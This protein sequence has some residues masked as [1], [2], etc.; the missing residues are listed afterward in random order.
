MW[1]ITSILG[2]ATHM[3]SVAHL[4]ALAGLAEFDQGV[5]H[6]PN[7]ANRTEGLSLEETHLAAWQLE[8][9]EA[10]I[11]RQDNCRS[12]GCSAHHTTSRWILFHIV[13]HRADRNI[14]QCQGI[15]NK[16][17]RILRRNHLLPN[18]HSGGMQ[19]VAA[20]AIFIPHQADACIS[21][22]IILH[23]LYLTKY[24]S[25]LAAKV[26]GP[27]ELGLSRLGVSRLPR[28]PRGH[29]DGLSLGAREPTSV[30]VH[31]RIVAVLG[32]Y[33]LQGGNAA[34]PQSIVLRL[35]DAHTTCCYRLAFAT[36]HHLRAKH[37]NKCSGCCH[38]R[39]HPRA[40]LHTCH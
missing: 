30:H 36:H 17:C 8:C 29:A 9:N 40:L 5:L 22:W 37:C 1:V 39:Q 11:L 3:W 38:A 28:S 6:A 35:A 19:D 14:C 26:D 7:S 18:K 16:C 12:A 15:A 34:I 31:Q 32:C 25:L 10:L 23:G 27:V 13:D 21:I 33:L 20:L 2:T 24:A 4:S